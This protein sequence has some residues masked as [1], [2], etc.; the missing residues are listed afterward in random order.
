MGKMI[1][2]RCQ[3]GHIHFETPRAATDALTDGVESTRTASHRCPVSDCADTMT[4][5]GPID[6]PW[7]RR[8][9]LIVNLEEIGAPTQECPKHKG[10]KER[11]HILTDVHPRERS[12]RDSRVNVAVGCGCTL[13]LMVSP[14][15]TCCQPGTGID[16]PICHKRDP[17]VRVVLHDTRGQTICWG[18]FIGSP[19]ADVQPPW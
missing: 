7:G 18:C 17:T 16:C 19:G 5:R 11:Y 12:D 1:E 10:R 8:G 3:N 15:D 4:A 14:L 9:N 6:E 2:Y 13:T